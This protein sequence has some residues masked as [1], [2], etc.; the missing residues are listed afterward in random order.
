M[1]NGMPIRWHELDRLDRQLVL[2]LQMGPLL[3][4]T[5]VAEILEVERATP[6]R[7]WKLLQQRHLAR[8]SVEPQLPSFSDPHRLLSL[9]VTPAQQVETA[10]QIMGDPKIAAVF[11]PSGSDRIFAYCAAPEAAFP[12]REIYNQFGNMRGVQSI[13]LSFVT[14][15]SRH[16]GQYQLRPSGKK[17]NLVIQRTRDF[18]LA[19][20][21]I[22][23]EE[24]SSPT[25]GP[26]VS[27]ALLH[28]LRTDARASLQHLNLVENQ[29]RSAAGLPEVSIATTRRERRAL[30]ESPAN[31]VRLWLPTRPASMALYVLRA[32]QHP[33]DR[34]SV[35]TLLTQFSPYILWSGELTGPMNTMTVVAVPRQD[36]LERIVEGLGEAGAKDIVLERLFAYAW[37]AGMHTTGR[38]LWPVDPQTLKALRTQEQA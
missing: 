9:H 14:R 28:E 12:F 27:D 29:A 10:E 38:L 22:S 26:P 21:S 20:S 17:E 1:L 23:S 3:P 33:S 18:L 15:S 19:Q 11:L 32:H 24:P 2:V 36:I 4:W 34:A 7:R 6:R 25:P 13:A 5:K 31:R 37:G 16:V 30:L 35:T 8:I